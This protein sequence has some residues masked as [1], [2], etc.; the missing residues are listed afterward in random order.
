VV[1]GDWKQTLRWNAPLYHWTK[2]K[3]ALGLGGA[4]DWCAARLGRRDQ[5]V[6]ERVAAALAEVDGRLGAATAERS[7]SIGW[8]RC[9]CG[10]GVA[11]EAAALRVA[12]CVLLVAAARTRQR[13]D[14]RTGYP[15]Q[16]SNVL[17]RHWRR[18]QTQLASG[19][20]GRPLHLP[21]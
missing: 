21:F 5:V 3:G 2:P 9:R 6:A 10:P 20:A 8:S 4:G 19:S 15:R 13:P 11:W 1:V 14:G 16:P 18:Q 7:P 17:V 12:A